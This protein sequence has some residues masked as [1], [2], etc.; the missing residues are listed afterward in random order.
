MRMRNLGGGLCACVVVGASQL[1]HFFVRLGGVLQVLSGFAV[2]LLQLERSGCASWGCGCV[3][4]KCHG[5][6]S[7][8]ENLPR[9]EPC[10]TDSLNHSQATQLRSLWACTR[11]GDLFTTVGGLLYLIRL[12]TAYHITRKRKTVQPPGQTHRPPPTA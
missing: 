5:K 6:L 2:M 9:C 4:F 11:V 12:L 8:W 10:A 7:K 1:G 3:G